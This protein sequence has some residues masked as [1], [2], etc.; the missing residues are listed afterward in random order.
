MPDEKE[1]DTAP[2]SS[3]PPEPTPPAAEVPAPAA[4]PEDW[5][6]RFKY[7]FADFENFRKRAAKE[8]EGFRRSVRGDVILAM[9]PSYEA[10]QRAREAVSRLPPNDPVRRGIDLLVREF[11]TFF[12]N[13]HV[14]PVARRGEPFRPEWHEAVAEA[15]PTQGARDGMVVE[16]IQQGYRI[17]ALLLRPAKVVV[18][19]A[20]SSAEPGAAA[21]EAAGE[22]DSS[23]SG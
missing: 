15:A 13:E 8:R 4:E 1:A 14:T 3:A 7:L 16:I 12:D 5:E 11:L 10:A 23:D 19:R 21:A 17:D 2:P 20:P 22:P 6:T 9:I 18:A